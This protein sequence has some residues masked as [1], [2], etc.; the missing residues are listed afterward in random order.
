MVGRQ[1]RLPGGLQSILGSMTTEQEKRSFQ[2]W[3]Y[4]A[5]RAFMLIRSP[6]S[7]SGQPNLDVVFNGVEYVEVTHFLRKG[8][9]I[10]EPT[11]DETA[12]VKQ[13]LG[14]SFRPRWVKLFVLES[15]DQRFLVA[16][17]AVRVVETQ[18]DIHKPVNESDYWGDI[19]DFGTI[20]YQDRAFE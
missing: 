3:D 8:L 14:S 18:S 9:R 15:G 20:V 11:D 19:G 16:A 17:A 7:G 12:R 5:D 10:V 2:I 4:K 6:K 13:I 1:G